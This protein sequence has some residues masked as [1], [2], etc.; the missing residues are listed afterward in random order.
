MRTLG[1]VLLL[2]HSLTL[3]GIARLYPEPTTLVLCLALFVIGGVLAALGLF[4]SYGL[5][6][7]L[8]VVTAGGVGYGLATRALWLSPAAGLA[9]AIVAMGLTLGL[10]AWIRSRLQRVFFNE[11]LVVIYPQNG[12]FG[13]VQGP[14]W[15]YPVAGAVEP[16]ALMPCY[17]QEYELRLTRVNTRP[18]P[19]PL[20]E[21]GENIDELVVELVFQLHPAN[22]LRIFGVHNQEAI[23]RAAAT[24]AG[25]AMPAAMRDRRFWSAAWRHALADITERIVR[26]E[27]HR[28]GLT[29]L[30]VRHQR[31]RIEAAVLA[32][33]RAEATNLGLEILECNLL[34]VEP[35][36][37]SATMASRETMLRAQGRAEE[38]A[39]TG[40]AH[41]MA[42]A[43]LVRE[44]V[45]AVRA[46]GAQVSPRTIDLIV[47]GVLPQ[48]LLGAYMR[49]SADLPD[50]LMD[51]H[52]RPG[53]PHPGD[54]ARN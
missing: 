37:A 48:A 11:L 2:I 8:S 3:I 45:A 17:Q 36:E 50:T 49:P 13:V 41:A 33:L 51:L 5:L 22:C 35:D 19:G 38:I 7:A 26:T 34:Q 1:F 18:Q 14:A 12:G 16:L 4:T 32:R 20:G 30:E 28:S 24:E 21:V 27:V 52:S 43:A 23:F 42:R 44:V 39:I 10:Q 6:A 25:A 31:E 47:Q 15:F 9:M 40:E 46:S 53:G 54:P 29:A